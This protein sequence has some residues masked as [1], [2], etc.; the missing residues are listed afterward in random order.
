M[1]KG[2]RSA[3][4]HSPRRAMKKQKQLQEREKTLER[5]YQQLFTPHLL[6]YHGLYT[7]EDNLEQPSALKAY[8]TTTT[9]GVEINTELQVRRHAQ[10]E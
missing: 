4:V 3:K 5:E 6:P 9:P 2:K 10:L 7:D 8:P 1:K